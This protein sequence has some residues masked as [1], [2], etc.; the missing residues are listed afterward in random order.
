MGSPPEGLV[1]FIDGASKGNPETTAGGGVIRGDRGEWIRGFTE[2]FRKCTPVKPKLR[3]LL[4]GFRMGRGTGLKKIWFRADSMIV[5]GMLR[6]NGSWNP[7]HK[8][9]ILQCKQLI[10]KEDWEVK[11]SHCY[12]EGN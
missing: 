5:V 10:E 4:H 6:G 12:R 8:P 2:N 1:L 3:V 11:I 7:I 9:F